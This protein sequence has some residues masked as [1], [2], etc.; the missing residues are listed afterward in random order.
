MITHKEVFEW[1]HYAQ[2]EPNFPKYFTTA[3]SEFNI[4]R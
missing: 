4:G 3:K 1:K 2:Y